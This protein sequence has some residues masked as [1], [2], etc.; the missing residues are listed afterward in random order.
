MQRRRINIEGGRHLVFY[1]FD[2]ERA[3]ETGGN[4]A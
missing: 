3:N 2:A 4:A 1:T